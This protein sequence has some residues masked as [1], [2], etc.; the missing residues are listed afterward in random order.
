MYNPKLSVSWI[1][2]KEYFLC[3]QECIYYCLTI[4]FTQM[5]VYIIHT[6]LFLV[7]FFSFCTSWRSWSISIIYTTVQSSLGR[8]LGYYQHFAI[9]SNTPSNMQN[10]CWINSW[11]CLLGQTICAFIILMAISKSLTF[12]MSGIFHFYPRRKEGKLRFYHDAIFW[13]N[14]RL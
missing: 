10:I 11:K 12:T 8:Y 13:R 2:F 9:I 4:Y 1:S 5:A 14:A 7:F 6:V 3:K